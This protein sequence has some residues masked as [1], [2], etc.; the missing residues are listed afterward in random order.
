MNA[1][2]NQGI[3]ILLLAIVMSVFVFTGAANSEARVENR[4]GL[5]IVYLEG[6]PYDLG[7][8]QGSMLK[9]DVNVVYTTYLND[10]VYEDWVKKYAILKGMSLAYKNPRKGMA[11]FAQNVVPHVPEYYLEEMKGLAEGAGLDYREVV[12]M[13]VHVDYFAILLCSTLVASGPATLDGNLIEARNLD[14]ASGA[15]K[16]LDPLSTMFVYKPDRGHAFMSILYPGIVGALTAVNDAK[17][18]VELNFSMATENGTEGFPAMLIVRHIAQN[19]ATLDEAEALLREMP[20]I[21]GYNVMVTDG[22]TNQARLIEINTNT[23][24]TL[25]LDENGTLVTTNHFTTKALEGKNVNTNSFSELPS[26]ERYVRL[27]EMLAQKR[28]SIG[29]ADAIEMIHDKQIKCSGT[30]QTVIFKPAEDKIWVWTR[31]R[32]P[33]DF[34]ELDVAEMLSKN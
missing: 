20:R 32:K 33:G 29:P 26:P 3:P 12:N 8:Q 9:E 24:D 22:K 4:D 5:K 1:K 23:V 18:T 15:A 34:L 16:E 25:G 31:S 11:K 13:M 30:V 28:G 14:W 7:F 6:S 2:R 17:L 21:A 10:L 19:A 27:H